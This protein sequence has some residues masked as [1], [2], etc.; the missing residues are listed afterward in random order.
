[1]ST[2]TQECISMS[3]KRKAARPAAPML[4]EVEAVLRKAERMGYS[5]LAL[6][7]A[8][9]IHHSQMRRWQLGRVSPT[10]TSLH[11]MMEFLGIQ[12]IQ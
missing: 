8:C 4:P 11:K 3:R 9:G 2:T 12:R 7:R 6:A 1:M 5:P 10:L